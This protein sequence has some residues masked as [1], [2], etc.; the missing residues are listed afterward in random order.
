MAI[1]TLYAYSVHGHRLGTVLESSQR[2][3]FP[4]SGGARIQQGQGCAP[5]TAVKG[6]AGDKHREGGEHT[7][8][9]GSQR[10]GGERA[11]AWPVRARVCKH[12]HPHILLGISPALRVISETPL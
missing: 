10:R 5:M 4:Y 9:S 8:C 3:G 7:Q 6:T 2:T 1:I 12:A 11:H